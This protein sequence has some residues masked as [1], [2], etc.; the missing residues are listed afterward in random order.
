M[1][2]GNRTLAVDKGERKRYLNSG[3]PVMK[4]DLIS[5]HA[6]HYVLNS[7]IRTEFNHSL[8]SELKNYKRCK[9]LDHHPLGY[10]QLYQMQSYCR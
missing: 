6:H 7:H 10:A 2:P 3:S 9:Y 4:K 1:G 5:T 8:L